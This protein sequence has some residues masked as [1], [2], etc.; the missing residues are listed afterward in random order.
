VNDELPRSSGVRVQ[1]TLVVLA[2]DEDDLREALADAITDAGF[3]V[4]AVA[5][6]PNLE[7]V[8]DTH[9]PDVLLADFQLFD[10]TTEAV[11]TLVAA[12]RSI[13]RVAIVSAAPA[14]RAVAQRLAVQH[15]A[16]PFEL[17]R[18]LNLIADVSEAR[19]AG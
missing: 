15:I 6:V 13:P 9:Q 16:K 5:D 14:A 1:R 19:R 17:D 18:V 3:D 11:V 7:R 4:I 12:K 2:E 10:Q 8:L